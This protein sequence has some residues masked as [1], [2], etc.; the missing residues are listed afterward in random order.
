GRRASLRPEAAD[1]LP[2]G[3]APPAAE[4]GRGHGTGHGDA[5][6]RVEA[7]PDLRLEVHRARPQHG[8]GRRRRLRLERRARRDQGAPRLIRV[9]VQKFGGTSVQDAPALE[10]LAKIVG[11]SASEH[12]VVVVSAMGDTTDALVEAV[13]HAVR[14]DDAAA[15]ETLGKLESDT[16]SILDEVFGREAPGAGRDTTETS[17]ELRRMAS[18]IAVLKSVPAASR[19]NFLAHGERI[20]SN[21]A[22][23]AMKLRGLPAVAVD[24]RGVVI[25][26]DHFG[27]ARPDPVEIEKRAA[28][29]LLPVTRRGEIPVV[30]G[31]IGS[32]PPAR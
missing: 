27:R 3:D 16:K 24:S 9:I 28:E 11:R 20:S 8:P 6:R 1:S 30:G 5:R 32:P 13:D 22:A 23:R 15:R 29:I 21:V 14:G 18:A 17:E 25:T 7:V 31:F 26:D 4:K 10:R 19:D 12:P 2:A